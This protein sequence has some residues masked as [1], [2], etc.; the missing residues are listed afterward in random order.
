VKTKKGIILPVATDELF[1]NRLSV[2]MNVKNTY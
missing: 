2:E 1:T